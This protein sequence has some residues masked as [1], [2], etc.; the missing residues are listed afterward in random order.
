MLFV[1]VSLI[2]TEHKRRLQYDIDENV[3]QCRYFILLL[4]DSWGPAERHFQR[5]YRLALQLMESPDAPMTAV[6]CL[7]KDQS[8]VPQHFEGMPCPNGVFAAASEF[9]SQLTGIL[10]RWLDQIA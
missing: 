4:Q 1:P 8:P 9:D 5:D 10:S 3:R 2:A 6:A 7:Q